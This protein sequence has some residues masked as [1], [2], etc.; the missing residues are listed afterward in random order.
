MK[1]ALLYLTYNYLIFLGLIVGLMTDI[2]QRQH[3]HTVIVPFSV[4]CLSCHC[5]N[6][7]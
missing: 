1:H 3:E 4:Y 2:L 5:V 6:I 7:S